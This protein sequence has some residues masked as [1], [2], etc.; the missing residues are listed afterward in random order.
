MGF[1]G[2]GKRNHK[3]HKNL[4]AGKDDHLCRPS[5]RGLSKQ[6][7]KENKNTL[8]MGFSRIKCLGHKRKISRPPSALSFIVIHPLGLAKFLLLKINLKAR[9]PEINFKALG[10]FDKSRQAGASKVTRFCKSNAP[11]SKHA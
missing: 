10:A 5:Q 9:L 1:S 8:Q 11:T 3:W 4:R 7:N 6:I 2:S